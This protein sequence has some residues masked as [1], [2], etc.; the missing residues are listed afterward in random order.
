MRRK[1]AGWLTMAA[2]VLAWAGAATAQSQAGQSSTSAVQEAP[3]LEPV[4]MDT[5]KRMSDLLKSAKSFSFTYRTAHEQMAQTGQMVDFVH[6]AKVAIARPNKLRFEVTGDVRNTIL[7][8][9]GKVVTLLDPTQRFFTQLEAPPSIDEMLMVL[10]EKFQ[11]SFPV[12]GVLL[13]DPYEKMREGLK[14]A[15]DLGVTNVDGVDCRHLL[16]G[17][18]GADWQVWVDIGPRPLPRRLAI[19]YKNVPGAPR[20]LAAFS[21]WKLNPSIPPGRFVF[22]KPPGATPVEL[23]AAS[24]SN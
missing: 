9:D 10:M 17:E 20:V 18:D 6:L 19:V 21:D 22:V 14:T 23:K 3:P 5:L 15:V 1:S 8:Y 24:P 2:V 12:A 7:T 16:F 13:A 11:T 4:A